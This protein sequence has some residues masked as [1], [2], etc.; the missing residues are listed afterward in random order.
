MF[1]CSHH[2]YGVKLF[3]SSSDGYWFW[4]LEDVFPKECTYFCEVYPLWSKCG[5]RDTHTH[6][7][8]LNLLHSNHTPNA[9]QGQ[10]QHSDSSIIIIR[11]Y[12]ILIYICYISW[13][14]FLQA[15]QMAAR[16]NPTFLCIMV[17][18]TM[19]LWT[20]MELTRTTRKTGALLI[21]TC[22]KLLSLCFFSNYWSGTRSEAI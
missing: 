19:S 20:E 17:W 2:A 4:A 13:K 12:S 3:H 6:A 14:T 9:T 5:D 16:R 22:G 21:C 15:L 8:L 10:Y 18:L 11:Y 1:F 7:L